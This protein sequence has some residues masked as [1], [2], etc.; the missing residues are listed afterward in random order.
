MRAPG[1][2][3]ATWPRKNAST[4]VWPKSWKAP[5]SPPGPWTRKRPRAKRLFVLQVIQPGLAG[6]MDGS[7][8]TLA[9]LFAAAFATKIPIETFKVGLAASLG[10]GISMGFAEA[11]SDDGSL[12]GRGRP[13]TRG[14][15]CGLMTA[16]G[17]LGHTFPYLIPDIRIATWLAVAVVL[18]ELVV[19]SW[20]RYRFMDTSFSSAVFQV[21]VGGI[22][23]FLTGIV[24]GSS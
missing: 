12:T 9:P 10:A 11:L 16:V 6:L 15:I 20:I 14:F 13:W 3:W 22:L 7:V 23:V 24:I 4:P 18:V 2:F 19:I 5:S 1:S 8:S 17:G 21:M